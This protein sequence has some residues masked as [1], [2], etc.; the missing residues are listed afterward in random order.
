[1]NRFFALVKV[2]F[3]Q[4]LMSFKSPS[5]RG[6]KGGASGTRAFLVLAAISLYISVAYSMMFAM[7][8]EQ[9][10]HLEL[11]M[12]VMAV[13][14]AAMCLMLTA[15]SAGG[16]LFGGKDSDLLLSLPVSA[17][18]V[19]LSKTLALY[20][21]N[22]ALA[23]FM[24]L[25]AGVTYMIKTASFSLSF[26]IMLV[27]STLVLSLFTTLA[28]FV[29]GVVLTWLTSRTK[30]SKLI[31]NLLYFAFFAGVMV[32]AFSINN[33]S[34][35]FANSASDIVERASGIMWIFATYHRA[36]FGD[37]LAF[38]LL[39]AAA[40]VPFL[41][42]VWLF[43]RSYK[44]VINSI[45]GVKTR[46][47]YRMG[48]VKSTSQFTALVRKEAERYF[49]TPL[50]LFNTGFGLVL[51]IAG[52]VLS[53]IYRGAVMA[54]LAEAQLDVVSGG[55]TSLLAGCVCFLVATSCCASIS[56]SLERDR[57]WI[58][59]ESP[60]ATMSIFHAKAA[61]NIIV[62]GAAALVACPLLGI[63]LGVR[64]HDVAGIFVLSMALSVFMAYAGL[65]LNLKY[66]KLD[67]LN[68]TIII[69]QSLAA[70][71]PILGGMVLVGGATVL[72]T[73][74]LAG[75]VSFWSYALL[76]TALLAGLTALCLR[77]L[78]GWGTRRFA[79]L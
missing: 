21:Q 20:M 74:L 65:L 51:L 11:L 68:D 4:L 63:A 52:G 2:A 67:A 30:G 56:I 5:R 15:F 33:I 77:L 60:V 22:A 12:F 72:Y 16:L 43:S 49:G 45:G 58:L 19:M 40:V 66:P 53:L 32:L 34:A 14:S 3:L 8:L 17:F 71:L 31:S 55:I 47:D 18:E 46:S 57:L 62:N 29:I 61:F 6:N 9:A 50:Y 75:R 64:A 28:A 36:V 7:Q 26:I 78:A 37:I 73:V 39:L 54:F 42:L 27:L 69:K 70:M 23:F 1:M 79:E 10:G 44:K 13:V 38:A 48:A 25:P 24:M 76:C 35:V 41:A 59:K